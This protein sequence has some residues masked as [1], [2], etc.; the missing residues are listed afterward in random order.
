[1]V[2]PGPRDRG[3][4]R[5]NG[6]DQN[7]HHKKP[8]HTSG[9]MADALKAAL[10]GTPLKEKLLG[11][12][13][14]LELIGG[15]KFIEGDQG[16]VQQAAE[17][18]GKLKPEDAQFVLDK[19]I[20]N[21]LDARPP[22]EGRDRFPF[23]SL[24]HAA[25]IVFP[26]IS[27][28]GSGDITQKIDAGLKAT[29]EHLTKALLGEETALLDR[30]VRYRDEHER[31]EWG[32]LQRIG[33]G[34][35]RRQDRF[36]R[37]EDDL[38]A[39]DRRDKDRRFGGHRIGQAAFCLTTL[40]HVAAKLPEE[41]DRRRYLT[42]ID[43]W[44]SHIKARDIQ[45]AVIEGIGPI[46][47][48]L[49]SQDQLR[50]YRKASATDGFTPQGAWKKIASAVPN[51]VSDIEVPTEK[52]GQSEFLSVINPS[53]R[54]KDAA[55]R[56]PAFEKLK[57][58]LL[59]RPEDEWVDIGQSAGIVSRED[60]YGSADR[61]SFPP[62]S[63]GKQIGFLRNVLEITSDEDVKFG[64]GRTLL[65][66]HVTYGPEGIPKLGIPPQADI[67]DSV[68]S[69]ASTMKDAENVNQ[70]A[71]VL[72]QDLE[73]SLTYDFGLKN[74]YRPPHINALLRLL[75]FIPETSAMEYIRFLRTH[76]L[77]YQ[78]PLASIPDK[79]REKVSGIV[80]KG[81]ESIVAHGNTLEVIE[82]FRSDEW[83]DARHHRL[84][85]ERKAE[86]TKLREAAEVKIAAM[87]GKCTQD[88]L[89]YLVES[90]IK[91]PDT[92][93]RDTDMRWYDFRD[94]TNYV[95]PIEGDQYLDDGHR[96]LV[97]KMMAE[98]LPDKED[99]ARIEELW[100]KHY[101]ATRE[102]SDWEIQQELGDR[103]RELLGR[104]GEADSEDATREIAKQLEQLD[105]KGLPKE[106]TPNA[107]T[108]KSMISEKVCH[109]LKVLGRTTSAVEDE[110]ERRSIADQVLP[111][112][113]HYHS[114]VI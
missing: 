105:Q 82:F 16:A 2:A 10:E 9:A 85:P 74:E 76:E 72:H 39:D 48:T 43:D 107:P 60:R 13:N 68:I 79:E 33:Q 54:S 21:A 56:D 91:E 5:P 59:N 97:S 53:L 108:E 12:Q 96:V 57:Q 87:L 111:W 64:Y 88:D 102:K 101:N 65:K 34:R 7:R 62:E 18:A 84:D 106:E 47:L 27:A 110:A 89:V 38:E 23:K 41:A 75:P 4:R 36:G 103:R 100:M 25:R 58:Y 52:K 51:L 37:D 55:I 99:Q 49:P 112:V 71:G 81:E 8:D 114:S 29:A 80:A 1:M 86:I 66:N 92:T 109:I 73:F 50:L 22:R 44:T 46:A 11:G 26:R 113:G 6:R 70:L 94:Q 3:R 31:F 78:G 95:L 63:L 15:Q 24:A 77:D 67:F 20:G 30:G 17:I 93:V 40:G 104:L 45:T 90:P 32:L 69:A 28:E 61:D 42:V 19:I 98:A 35:R 83:R 14:F